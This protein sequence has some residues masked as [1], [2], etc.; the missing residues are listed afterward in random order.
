MLRWPWCV[1]EKR[2]SSPP[3]G[4]AAVL[5]VLIG[6]VTASAQLATDQVPRERILPTQE[7]LKQQVS[8]GRYRLGPIRIL[9]TLVVNNAG[10]DNNVFGTPEVCPPGTGC[11]QPKTSDWSASVSA[12]AQLV[13]PVGAKIY[14]RGAVLPE[15][16]WYRQ[17]SNRRTFGGLYQ[18]SLLGFFNRMTLEVG[19]YTSRTFGFLSSET[20]TRVVQVVNDGSA[21]V[22]VD[23]SRALSLFAAAEALRQRLGLSGELPASSVDVRSLDRDEG[24]ARG[25]I[26]YKISP[27]LDV[28]AAVEETRSEFVERPREEDNQSLAYLLGIYY[29]RPRFF[30]NLSG[31]YRRGRP[32]NQSAFPEYKTATG[33]YFV[34][35][36]LLR[37]LEAQVYGRRG[38]SYGSLFPRPTYFIESRTGGGLNF[39]VHPRVLLRGYGEYGTNDYSAPELLEEVLTKRTDKVSVLGG[40]FSAL[41]Y[42]KVVLTALATRSAYT[43]LFPGLTRTVVRITTTLSFAGELAR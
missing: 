31:G 13:A 38:I 18:A 4:V 12:G 42:R 28:S 26:R 27:Q 16:I 14:M 21:K 11:G 34:S 40:G 7:T 30:V 29:N 6:R 9:P 1:R 39:E 37:K 3:L 8:K 22:E 23:I 25:G 2:R 36:F 43:S 32:Y 24:A 5:V 35:Y 10:Y 20:E 19:G 15:Y 33:S 41:L 17:L